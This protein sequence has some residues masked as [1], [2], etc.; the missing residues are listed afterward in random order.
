MT[1]CP[2]CDSKLIGAEAE[3]NGK[4]AAC[5]ARDGKGCSPASSR[6][7]AGRRPG[8]S[9]ARVA[10]HVKPVWEPAFSRRRKSGLRR[11]FQLSTSL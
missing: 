11:E 8:A 5:P 3:G 1:Q 6:L 10:E 2:D 4:C 7:L 9:S